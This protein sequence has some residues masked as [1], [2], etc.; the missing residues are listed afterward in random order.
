MRSKGL[1]ILLALASL[2]VC[3]QTSSESAPPAATAVPSPRQHGPR[4]AL[5]LHPDH[6]IGDVTVAESSN[7]SGY[8]VTGSSFT[9]AKGSWIVPAVDCSVVPNSSTSFW[10]GIDGWVNATVEQ[11]GTDSDCDGERP[12]YYAWY[13]FAPRGGVTI[14]SV[15]VFPGDQMSGEISYDDPYF[16][17]TITNETTGK[18]FTTRSTVPDA[19]RESAEWITEL[20]S[21][22][23]SDFGTVSF[24]GDYTF[25]SGTN[26]AT[27]SETSGSIS[28][29]DNHV[30][31]SILATGTGVHE[32]VPSSLSP[33]GTSFTVTW[34]SD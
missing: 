1:G 34:K 4:K 29:F 26:S 25:V 22:H 17:V 7:W 31:Q 33:D 9:E 32:A 28:D 23:L 10:V 12:T 6:V 24:G 11:T 8:A 21:Y 13:E 14:L 30:W 5:G 2:T 18:S 15:P 3:A 16:T 20:N 27:D 19:H